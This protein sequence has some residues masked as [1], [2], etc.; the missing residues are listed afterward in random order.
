MSICSFCSHG[1]T[2]CEGRE[3]TTSLTVH[4]YVRLSR[5]PVHLGFIGEVLPLERE[6]NNPEDKFAVAIIRR[7]CV[8]GH[9]P[10][11]LVPVVSAFL[12]RGVNKGVVEVTGTKVNCGAGYGLEIPY[13]YH[14]HGLK[15]Y[16]QT[17]GACR[18]SWQ[19]WT[20]VAN[21]QS[22]LCVDLAIPACII[23]IFSARCMAKLSVVRGVL[24]SGVFK[25]LKSS[26][27]QSGLRNCPLYHGCLPLRGVC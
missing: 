17:E 10:F 4:S 22:S 9:L 13:T 27:K 8:V 3:D 18:G 15:L 21:S 14:F 1:E 20:F 19:W 5:L 23:L 7:S 16:W 6:P 26:E 24:Y 11:N 2:T 25:V 12:R